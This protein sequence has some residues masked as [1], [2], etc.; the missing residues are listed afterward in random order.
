MTNGCSSVQYKKVLD[1][2]YLDFYFILNGLKQTIGGDLIRCYV[3][4]KISCITE[5]NR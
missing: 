1:A 3:T 4:I 5:S 2:Q